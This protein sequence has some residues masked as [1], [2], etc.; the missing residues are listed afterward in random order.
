MIRINGYLIAAGAAVLGAL[1]VTPAD[2]APTPEQ[3]GNM[4]YTGIYEHAIT[5]KNGRWEGD[6]FVAGRQLPPCRWPD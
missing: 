2:A 5:L 1:A 3:L 4:A 6:P